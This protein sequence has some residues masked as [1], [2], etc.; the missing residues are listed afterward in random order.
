MRKEGLTKWKR[1]GNVPS[2]EN[3]ACNRAHVRVMCVGT[4]S[5]SAW[6]DYRVCVKVARDESGHGGRGWTRGDFSVMISLS[7]ARMQWE[8]FKDFGFECDWTK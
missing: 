3:R 6:A 4:S 1:G 5:N 2:R 7:F 8:P